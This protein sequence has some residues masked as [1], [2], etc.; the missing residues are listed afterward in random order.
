MRIPYATVPGDVP[1]KPAVTRL[2]V[3]VSVGST[4]LVIGAI[5][6]AIALADL[7]EA[8]R[9]PIAWVVATSIVAWLLSA[10]ITVLARRMPRP[11]ALVLTVLGFAILASGAW[12]GVRTTI[13]SEL[14]RLRTS[15]PSAAHD[16]EIHHKTAA[17]FHLADRAQSFVNNLDERFG[18]HAAAHAAAT[19]ASTYVVTGILMLFLLGYG[20]RFIAGA[21]RQIADDEKRARIGAILSRASGA[22]RSYLLYALAQAIV[23]ASLCWAVFYLLD[24]PAPFILGLLVGGLSTIPYFGIVL[25]GFAPLLAAAT[26]PHK[27]TYT[28][29]IAMLLV[30]QCIEAMVIRPRL[31]QRTLRVGPTLILVA[32]V[33]GFELYG[34]GG[35]LYSIAVLVSLSAVLDAMPD[36]SPPTQPDVKPS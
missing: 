21:L 4:L 23:I 30:L 17:N 13:K 24:L 29:L 3:K 1:P 5:V 2:R 36:R 12:I 15:L 8:A 35:A 28:I 32:I 22:A 25:G 10:V 34:F 14:D 6:A 27:A 33:V 31:D 11:L 9:R 16:L 20:P 19:A 18:T 26:D 7:F